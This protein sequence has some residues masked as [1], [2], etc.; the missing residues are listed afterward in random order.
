[1][2]KNIVIHQELL[3]VAFSSPLSFHKLKLI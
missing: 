1:M 3:P 2:T